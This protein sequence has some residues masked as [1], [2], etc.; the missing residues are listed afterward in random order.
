MQH[1]ATHQAQPIIDVDY[2]ASACLFLVI[3]KDRI[4]SKPLKGGEPAKF[5][6]CLKTPRQIR[7]M[8]LAGKADLAAVVEDEMN[9][10][11]AYSVWVYNF[12][13]GVQVARLK[14]ADCKA[15]LVRPLQ[16]HPVIITAST[17][18][19]SFW[20][21]SFAAVA[22]QPA[23]L[24][25]PQL[26]IELED[27]FPFSSQGDFFMNVSA[28]EADISFTKHIGVSGKSHLY[29][30]YFFMLDSVSQGYS[31][32][33]E[34]STD[35]LVDRC[36]VSHD[37]LFFLVHTTKKKF[38][39][40]E[41]ER[42]EVVGACDQVSVFYDEGFRNGS[43]ELGLF[44]PSCKFLFLLDSDLAMRSMDLRSCQSSKSFSFASINRQ[45]LSRLRILPLSDSSF[46]I[47]IEDKFYI[48]T[49]NN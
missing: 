13:L 18:R 32:L 37:S 19:V 46:V 23:V 35:S 3:D 15:F 17:S 47:A 39:L 2:F 43:F 48:Y 28:L 1:F 40:I 49:L 38:L 24:G 42:G 7:G 33:L 31:H 30:S 25:R 11:M 27:C 12:V 45:D 16:S 8:E 26:D 29:A 44:S 14:I 6:H 36:D 20:K 21:A 4:Y 22:T 9:L 10:D 41:T 34:F 5:L